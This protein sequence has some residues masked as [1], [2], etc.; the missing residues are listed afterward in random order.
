MHQYYFR[1]IKFH[2]AIIS[3]KPTILQCPIYLFDIRKT[4]LP[5]IQSTKKLYWNKLFV[6][7]IYVIKSIIYGIPPIIPI[8]PNLSNIEE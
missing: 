7:F 5:P 6:C 2:M 3:S 8:P 1:I 4:L